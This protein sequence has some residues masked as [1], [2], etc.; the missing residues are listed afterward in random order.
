MKSYKQYQEELRMLEAKAETATE[1]ELVE[2]EETYAMLENAAYKALVA[3]K[4]NAG[5]MQ[6]VSNRIT[7]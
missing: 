2:L 6:Q 5:Q 1:A 7:K 3:E 4:R